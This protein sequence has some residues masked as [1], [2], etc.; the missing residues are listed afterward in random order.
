MVPFTPLHTVFFTY[1]LKWGVE[2]YLTQYGLLGSAAECLEPL[3]QLKRE[4]IDEVAGLVDFGM[5]QDSV[6]TTLRTLAT[7]L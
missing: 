7:L 4:D 5:P 1:T 3:K 6:E 2:K